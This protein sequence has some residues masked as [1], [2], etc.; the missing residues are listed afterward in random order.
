MSKYIPTDNK[1]TGQIKPK[2]K[3]K[4]LINDKTH[5]LNE[6]DAFQMISEV[7]TQ[8][9]Q[10]SQAVEGILTAMEEAT[11]QLSG[12]KQT[13]LSMPKLKTVQAG[14]DDGKKFYNSDG[15]VKIES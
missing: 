8:I 11:Q 10:L 4:V 12:P 1:P 14:L 2:L 9:A 7:K 5:Y 13:K 3:V 15:G 6:Y